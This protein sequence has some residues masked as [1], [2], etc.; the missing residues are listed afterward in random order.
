MWRFRK[1]KERTS[2]SF[3]DDKYRGIKMKYKAILIVMAFFLG[4][5]A[6]PSIA[7]ETLRLEP[8][9][10]L[11]VKFGERE[12]RVQL[13]QVGEQVKIVVADVSE[14]DLKLKGYVWNQA[15]QSEQAETVDFT[16]TETGTY[17]ALLSR[18]GPAEVGS[19][20]YIEIR[21]EKE[22]GQQDVVGQYSFE[23]SH[24]PE[25]RETKADP[26]LGQIDTS[27]D[28][29]Q[30]P[31][32]PELNQPELPQ[33]EKETESEKA[34][35]LRRFPRELRQE[36]AEAAEIKPSG[37]IEIQQI[38]ANNGTFDVVIRDIRAPKAIQGVRVPVW[39]SK[40]G[41]DDLRWYEASRQADGTY[42]IRVRNENHNRETGSYHVH[43]YYHYEDG[44]QDGVGTAQVDLSLPTKPSGKI[45]IQQIDANNGTF[46]VVIRD[47]RAP[48]AVQGVRVP[49][50]TSKNG[51]DDLRWY[52][53]SRQADGTYYV[54]VRNENHNRETGSYHVHYYYHY[55]DGSQ[56]GV[57]TA[58][59][60]LP[61]LTKPSGKIEIQQ[62]DAN[63]GTFDV[64]I[65][66]IRAPKAVQGVRVPVWTSKNGQDDLRWYEASRQADGTYYVKVRNENHNRET[67]SYHV[68]YYYRYEDGSQEGV[69]TAR[70]D[71]PLPT[72]PSGTIAI[73]NQNG[74]DGRFD[75]VISNL[76]SPK[77][78]QRIFV[79]VWSA[80]GGRDDLRWYE[81]TKVGDGLYR[82]SIDPSNHGYDQGV[83]HVHWH[84]QYTDGV[85]VGAGTTRTTVSITNV[86]ARADIAVQK[87]NQVEGS[88]EVHIS[89]LRASATVDA[90]YVPVW[91]EVNGQND[92][93]W[94]EATK[95][96][97]GS[98][99]VAVYAGNHQFE[100][101]TYHAHV[102]ILNQGKHYG[103]GGV[104]TQLNV[105]RRSNTAFID[106]SSHNGYL[107]VSDYQHLKNQ[108]IR[109][110]VV[111][112]TEGT[113]YTNPYASSQ[114]SNARQAGLKVSAY[115]YS[116][117][118]TP[119][120]AKAEAA[121]F[122]AAAKRFGL[123]AN[124]VMVND[125]EE[126]KT[127]KNINAN[128]KEWE[129]EMRRLG[130]DNLIHYT[131]AS[132]IDVNTL[133]YAGPI[134]TGQFG[135]RN[136]WVAQYP[137]QTMTF[138]Q[139]KSMRLHAGTAAWQY[140]STAQLLPSRHVFDVNIDYT[141]RFTD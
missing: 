95:Q 1:K 122:V 127:R 120:E 123:S 82:V 31:G 34:P 62:I 65:R 87:L 25:E 109:G 117:F 58:R 84:V 140:T 75:V 19:F 80:K 35:V 40:N 77:E 11:A 55:E 103:V 10:D 12:G 102:Y 56:E 27:P 88:F 124:T 106:V 99:K 130:Y 78:I 51:Q 115:H 71:L 74:A 72:K 46:D 85:R 86:V 41:Q 4:F 100:E 119:I 52:E 47:I 13:E 83:Y 49:V 121:Y 97:D 107:S 28:L 44:S 30:V 53:A 37:T 138:D 36:L 18:T 135:L 98:Y 94:Y 23:W 76:R 104:K 33:F 60:D 112:L 125:I 7:A 111:K 14:V 139:A 59:A 134:Q 67:G 110:V 79:P 8:T 129:A 26:S 43:Y 17:E 6:I 91:A 70:A 69:G 96:V 39:T 105:S 93:I 61:L 131:G 114:I 3:F 108:G 89:N 50:W 16:L 54:R 29:S 21:T 128:M 136:F 45:E 81:A 32:Q 63:N 57:G 137:Y 24:H 9:Q 42:Y 132:W 101:G 2:N 141:G 66:D 133:G 38:D 48:K 64:V 113:S 15:E 5:A 92:I 68:H 90:V 20:S 118:T 73:E 126:Q 116:H 22:D